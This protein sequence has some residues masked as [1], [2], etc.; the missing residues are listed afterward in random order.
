MII[1]IYMAKETNKNAK[2]TYTDP[3]TGKFAEGNPGGGRPKGSESFKT[4]WER[5]VV[6]VAD[7]NELL[8]EDIDEQLLA[9]AYKKAKE[10]EYNFYK[11]IHDRVHGKAVQPSELDVKGDVNVVF[12]KE[13]NKNA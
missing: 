13:F 2:K 4:K 11:D 3:V 10:G 1:T 6:K 5:F 7:K 12:S 9:V 8:P